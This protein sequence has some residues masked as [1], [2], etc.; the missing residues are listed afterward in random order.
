MEDRVSRHPRYG[1]VVTHRNLYVNKHATCDFKISSPVTG[2]FIKHS[3]FFAS[4]DWQAV[5]K[6]DWYLR[7]TLTKD[8]SESFIHFTYFE[9][10][11]MVKTKKNRW[12]G[13]SSPGK[14]QNRNQFTFLSFWVDPLNWQSFTEIG[15]MACRTSARCF[16]GHALKRVSL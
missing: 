2:S 15:E 5:N 1:E 10:I 12:G 11:S 7:R 9:A 14:N 8:G 3:R 6:I 13:L 4:V 16:R